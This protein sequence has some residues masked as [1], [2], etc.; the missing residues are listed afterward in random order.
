[1]HPNVP[2]K[3]ER[4]QWPSHLS[5]ELEVLPGVWEFAI[6]ELKCQVPSA[7]LG[8][9]SETAIQ[10][11]WTGNPRPLLDLKTV[12]AAHVVINAHGR[13]PSTLLGHQNLNLIASSVERIRRLNMSHAFTSF[14]LSAAGRESRVL[15]RFREALSRAI[16][17]P[18]DQREGE[19]LI[20]LRP[21]P[22]G[23]AWQV[24]LRLTPR[25]LSA[26]KW[27]V[28]DLL[29]AV[30]STIAAAMVAM[31]EP[32]PTDRFFNPMCGS[33]TLMIERL[34]QGPASTLAG[35]DLVPATLR[36]TAANVHA[37]ELASKVDLFLADVGNLPCS[38][39]YFNKICVDPPWGHLVGSQTQ[40][41]RLYPLLL[42][43]LA[44]VTTQ[45]VRLILLTDDLKRFDRLISRQE[46]WQIRRSIQVYQGGH[47][48]RM[49]ELRK[50]P[51]EISQDRSDRQ[52]L[53]GGG[54][55]EDAV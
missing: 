55:N 43:E 39:N 1:L 26:R 34:H 38:A 10:L 21:A 40:N 15:S 31:T 52:P 44:R 35:C 41:D 3:H 49:Y 19:L 47:H 13:R 36:C 24:L 53:R 12:V 48:P 6:A 14:R 50:L 25:P 5:I 4:D 51:T 32:S 17:L 30:N 46:V 37:A 9:V 7:R 20:R 16:G 54:V 18:Y 22:S 27:R 2:L 29:G 28:C 33:G 45:D 42:K 8:M 23:S 11:S